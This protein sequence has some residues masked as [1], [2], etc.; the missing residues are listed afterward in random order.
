MRSNAI[1]IA[2]RAQKKQKNIVGRDILFLDVQFSSI[3]Q[4]NRKMS[5]ADN[6]NRV[7]PKQSK[8]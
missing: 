6:R 8:L 4:E 3:S 2:L 7:I 1:C 5:K